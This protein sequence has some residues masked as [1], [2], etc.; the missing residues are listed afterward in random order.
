MAGRAVMRELAC[1]G[2]A[3]SQVLQS[4]QC[5]QPGR[6]TVLLSPGR[7]ILHTIDCAVLCCLTEIKDDDLLVT[8]YAV[9]ARDTS[10]EE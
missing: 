3:W 10:E 9:E 1:D 4:D 5:G 6:P 7:W 2:P 8:Y